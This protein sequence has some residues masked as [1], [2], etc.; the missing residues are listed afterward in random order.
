MKIYF[1]SISLLLK[2]KKNASHYLIRPSSLC[3][4]LS[5]TISSLQCFI[6]SD[7]NELHQSTAV[8]KI[9]RWK[10][11]KRLKKCEFASCVFPLQGWILPQTCW[12]LLS[13]AASQACSAPQRRRHWEMTLGSHCSQATTEA[14]LLGQNQAWCFSD[15]ISLGLVVPYCAL[16]R[17]DTR[18]VRW[19]RGNLCPM[20]L[21]CIF[22]GITPMSLARVIWFF[23]LRN[24]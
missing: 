18:G 16:A 17:I 9:L 10:M 4:H 19:Q 6:Y 20:D 2:K 15:S 24:D 11:L 8:L 23:F 22:F 12:N 3:M 14:A 1:F 21:I 5:T 13:A 7:V